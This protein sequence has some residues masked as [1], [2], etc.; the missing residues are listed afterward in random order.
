MMNLFKF[1]CGIILLLLSHANG[2]QLPVL[3]TNNIDAHIGRMTL[4]PAGN[5]RSNA[6]FRFKKFI[7]LAPS[8]AQQTARQNV[9]LSLR[10]RLADPHLGQ[11]LE[12][13]LVDRDSRFL[14]ERLLKEEINTVAQVVPQHDNLIPDTRLVGTVL[15]GGVRKL[16]GILIALPNPQQGYPNFY[17]LTSAHVV[18]S[19]SLM[20][21]DVDIAFHLNGMNDPV[22]LTSLKIFKQPGRNVGIINLPDNNP[23]IENTLHINDIRAIP[24]YEEYG[25][26]ALMKIDPG[27]DPTLTFILMIV[28]NDLDLQRNGN[29]AHL[30][31]RVP[32]LDHNLNIIHNIT[33]HFY[34]MNNGQQAQHL[35]NNANAHHTNYLLGYAD[36]GIGYN[37]YRSPKRHP[38]AMSLMPNPNIFSVNEINANHQVSSLHFRHDAPLYLGMSGGPIFYTEGDIHNNTFSVHIYGLQSRYLNR[39]SQG[40]GSF[41]QEALLP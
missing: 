14:Q 7:S 37:L 19:I 10:Q 13:D 40:I 6:S 24:R 28:N 41:L 25:D 2:A 36:V 31:M 11:I 9:I 29:G 3:S 5:L 34:F 16:T 17:V 32:N 35:I 21:N 22:P 15:V 26:I 39:T 1:L 18:E 30:T 27:W 4:R 33:Y 12:Q 38:Q 8:S 23:P 20:A